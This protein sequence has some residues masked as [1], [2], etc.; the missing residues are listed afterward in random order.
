MTPIVKWSIFKRVNSKTAANYC[1]L[2]LAEKFYTI[3]SVDDKNLLNKKY[4][5]VNK[6]WHQ[7]KWLLSNGKRNDIMD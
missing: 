5:L 7:D 2:C 4:E 1:K 3:Q 6:C